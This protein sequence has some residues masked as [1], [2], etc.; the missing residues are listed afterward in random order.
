MR[1]YLPLVAVIAAA[2]W[3]AWRVTGGS[4]PGSGGAG[5]PGISRRDTILAI[6]GLDA[7]V[8]IVTDRFGIPHV[9]ARTR[10]DLYRAWG[11]VSARDRLWQLENLRAQVEGRRWRWL[12]NR[13]LAQDGGAQLFELSERAERIWER[14]RANPDVAEALESYAAGI[15]AYLDLCRRGVVPWPREF[16]L[17]HAEPAD[18]RASDA[19]RVLFGEAFLLD[20]EVPELAESDSIARHG[21]AWLD[22]RYR[23][24]GEREYVTIP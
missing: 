19:Y 8:T 4:S 6:A 5:V 2:A 22:T 10:A 20:F 1:R 21:A 23:F 7:P 18:W 12:G 9:H 3:L 14:D 17:V 16:T 11:F 13:V 24:E 15:N